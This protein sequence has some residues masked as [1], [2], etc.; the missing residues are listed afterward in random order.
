MGEMKVGCF[1]NKTNIDLAKDTKYK[2][3]NING[4]QQ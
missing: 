1:F 3:K 2:E 4:Q